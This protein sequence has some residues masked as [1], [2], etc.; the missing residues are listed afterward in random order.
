M[1]SVNLLYRRYYVIVQVI[2]YYTVAFGNRILTYLPFND[3][4]TSF[5][6]RL[7][8]SHRK[9]GIW[10]QIPNDLLSNFLFFFLIFSFF[11]S[12][13]H[14][15]FKTLMPLNLRQNVQVRI[16]PQTDSKGCRVLLKITQNLS[17]KMKI[18]KH[19]FFWFHGNWTK[20]EF[21]AK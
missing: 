10:C 16:N 21:Y 8:M 7:V 4:Q 13:S 6:N 15:T 19:C 9:N 12:W 2:C 14:L 3:F 5:S 11:P 17:Q 18:L 1:S 20:L